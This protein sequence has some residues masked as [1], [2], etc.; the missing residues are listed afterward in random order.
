MFVVV[1]DEHMLASKKEERSQ[2]RGQGVSLLQSL[3]VDLLS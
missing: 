3:A 1:V 2:A